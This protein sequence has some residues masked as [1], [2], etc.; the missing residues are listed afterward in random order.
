MYRGEFLKRRGCIGESCESET[1]LGMVYVMCVRG[2][3]EV[4]RRI[5]RNVFAKDLE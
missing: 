2:G 4:S 3:L 5:G 1:S